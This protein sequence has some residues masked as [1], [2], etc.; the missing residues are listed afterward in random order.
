M[1]SHP[2]ANTTWILI[3]DGARARVLAQEKDFAPLEPAFE[4]EEITGTRAQSK[5]IASDRPGRSFDSGGEGGHAM[6]PPTDPQRYAKFE[7]ARDLAERLEDAVHR[8]RFARL[9]LIAAPK[10]LGDLR[11]L[12]PES[13]KA[14][15]VAEIDKDLTKVPRP[16]LGKHLGEVLKLK[17]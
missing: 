12:L 3:A 2:I 15:V 5:E 6:E 9:M 8:G 16:E 13:V 14:K 7:F 11:E 17:R 10:T 1:R 4:D